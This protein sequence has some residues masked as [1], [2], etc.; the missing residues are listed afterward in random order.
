MSAA[1]AARFPYGPASLASSNSSSSSSLPPSDADDPSINLAMAAALGSAGSAP[2]KGMQFVSRR[3]MV[4]F[5]DAYATTHGF[6]FVQRDNTDHRVGIFRGTYRCWCSEKP[7][8]ND[9]GVER[10]TNHV[11]LGKANCSCPYRVGYRKDSPTAPWRITSVSAE[12]MGHVLRPPPRVGNEPVG[13]RQ[14]QLRLRKQYYGRQA[15]VPDVILER[16]RELMTHSMPTRSWLL[17]HISGV[18]NLEFDRHL[19]RNMYRS[20]H[21]QINYQPDEK[22]WQEAIRRARE[23]LPVEDVL[24]DAYADEATNRGLRL[25]FM[26]PTM[27]ANF[28]RNGEV[29]IMDTTHSTNKY[30]YRLLLLSGISHFGHTCVLVAALLRGEATDDFVWVL[31]AVRQHVGNAAWANVQ[32]VATDGDAAM[33][34]ALALLLPHAFHLRC[35]WHVQRN[36]ADRSSVWLGKTCSAEELDAFTAASNKVLF[37]VTRTDAQQALEDLYRNYPDPRCRSYFENYIVPILDNVAPYSVDVHVTFGQHATSRSES[38]HSVLKREKALSINTSARE[39]LT[40][41]YKYAAKKEQSAVEVDARAEQKARTRPESN[42]GVNLRA[43]KGVYA[44]AIERLTLYAANMITEHYQAVPNYVV[45]S[46]SAVH[47]DSAAFTGLVQLWRCRRHG[48]AQSDVGRAVQIGLTGGVGDAPGYMRCDCAMPANYLLPCAHVMAVNQQVFQ[49][50]LVFGQIGRRWFR[51][52]QRIAEP[53]VPVQEFYAAEGEE[54]LYDEDD[55]EYREDTAEREAVAY[56]MGCEDVHNMM[57]AMLDSVQNRP[58]VLDLIRDVI[59]ALKVVV[60]QR[61]IGQYQHTGLLAGLSVGA[62]GA[63]DEDALLERLQDPLPT[64]RSKRRKRI[65]S[66]GERVFVSLSQSTQPA[67]GTAGTPIVV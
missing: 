24:I 67:S 60:N 12:H 14:G 49:T 6:R 40:W 29:L 15:D 41:L 13:E 51:A 63:G 1:P 25:V 45:D 2:A 17:T 50:P 8:Y 22:D 31:R 34:A 47:V 35:V 23:L 64:H 59:A 43:G 55:M 39:L 44:M 57:D 62:D 66:R 42:V 54:K 4:S 46:V 38:I 28:R 20:L 36:I 37:A 52:H 21:S 18:F 61:I 19:F 9:A 10:K 30:R 3:A 53:V 33:S 32:T 27:T 48:A 5:L 7:T 58:G 56:E 16:M 11:Q 26:S 65:P